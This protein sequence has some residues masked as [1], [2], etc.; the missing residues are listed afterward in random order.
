MKRIILTEAKLKKLMTEMRFVNDM[1]FVTYLKGNYDPKQFKEIEPDVIIN[2]CKNGLWACP[3]GTDSG[4]K[5]WCEKE[6]FRY[7]GNNEFTFKLTPGAKIYE[8]N[9]EEDL[10]RISTANGYYGIV[11][12]IDFPGLL[13][14]GYDGIYVSSDMV[15]CPTM[16][17]IAGLDIWDVESLCVFNPNVII[18]VDEKTVELNFQDEDDYWDDYDED[19]YE[20]MQ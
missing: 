16:N 17:G 1:I 3:I 19:E 6:N 9:T 4:W 12:V 15:G 13:K 8:I 7:I 11:K 2:K 20:E 14:N 18:P 10:K 5:D